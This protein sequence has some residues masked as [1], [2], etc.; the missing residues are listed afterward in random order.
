MMPAEETPPFH[1][2]ALDHIV[3]RVADI[4]RSIACPPLAP[5]A[6]I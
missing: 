3:L 2:C 4:E 6:Q 1:L 5:M